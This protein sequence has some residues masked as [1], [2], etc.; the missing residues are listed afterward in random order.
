MAHTSSC[1]S[2]ARKSHLY[3]CIWHFPFASLPAFPFSRPFLPPNKPEGSKFLN[4]ASQ[5]Q[6][7]RFRIA[8]GHEAV[9]L[10][11]VFQP[12]SFAPSDFHPACFPPRFSRTVKTVYYVARANCTASSQRTEFRQPQKR[13][14][15]L[16]ATG[17][18]RLRFKGFA[19]PGHSFTILPFPFIK[20]TFG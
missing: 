15:P 19:W 18:E 6:I 1:L 2:V 20:F 11:A 13:N 8:P 14:W 7:Q 12:T 4:A 9:M 10:T 5:A 17:G 3:H 16:R